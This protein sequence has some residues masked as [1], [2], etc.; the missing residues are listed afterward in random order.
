MIEEKAVCVRHK[1]GEFVE[2]TDENRREVEG[3]LARMK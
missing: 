3:K 1:N 2:S